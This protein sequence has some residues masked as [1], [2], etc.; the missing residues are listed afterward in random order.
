MT[1]RVKMWSPIP[2]IICGESLEAYED[3]ED[4]KLNHPHGTEFRTSGHYGS[5][6]IDGGDTIAINICNPCLERA[7]KQGHILIKI[8]SNGGGRGDRP[9]WAVWEPVYVGGGE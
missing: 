4:S 8:G 5:T 6:V 9:Q 1:E 3:F 2:C 7:K